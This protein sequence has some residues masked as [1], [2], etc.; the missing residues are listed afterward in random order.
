MGDSAG[1]GTVE[2]VLGAGGLHNHNAETS[3]VTISIYFRNIVYL[4]AMLYLVIISVLI[5][6]IFSMMH[7][8]VCGASVQVNRSL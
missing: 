3:F 6:T 5:K 2:S 7:A 4:S 8:K 1:R